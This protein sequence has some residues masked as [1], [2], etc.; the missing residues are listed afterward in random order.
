MNGVH[1]FANGDV[2][3]KFLSNKILQ[4]QRYGNPCQQEIWE[5]QADQEA[6]EF[7]SQ[8]TVREEGDEN[9]KVS[10]RA[11]SAY[12]HSEREVQLRHD[13]MNGAARRRG[14]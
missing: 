10:E 3:D 6:V 14:I 8:P 9:G 13:R 5:R 11:D 12:Q 7:C 1:E 4:L 2:M